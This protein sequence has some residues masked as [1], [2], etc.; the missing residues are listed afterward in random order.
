MQQSKKIY[1]ELIGE[2]LKEEKE[3]KNFLHHLECEMSSRLGLNIV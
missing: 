1:L 3:K 2:G